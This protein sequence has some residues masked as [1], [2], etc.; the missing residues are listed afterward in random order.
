MLFYCILI[1]LLSF[2]ISFS[3]YS[4]LSFKNS[5]YFY[6]SSSLC[7]YYSH[8]WSNLLYQSLWRFYILS[9]FSFYFCSTLP[10]KLNIFPWSLKV[11]SSFK[12]NYSSNYLIF[13][14]KAWI[15]YPAYASCFSVFINWVLFSSC[16]LFYE[17]NPY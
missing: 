13:S 7:S 9:F 3:F 4:D 11:S 10:S 2:L 14:Y 5:F 17:N 8:I 12:L 1:S 6:A 15:F 16:L